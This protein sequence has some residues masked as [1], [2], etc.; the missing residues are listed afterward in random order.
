MKIYTKSGDQGETQVYASEVL[1]K[2]KDDALLQCYGTLDELN[3]HIGLLL[4]YLNNNRVPV[5]ENIVSD[6]QGKPN[7]EPASHNLK[8]SFIFTKSQLNDDYIIAVFLQIQKDIFNIG[9]ALSNNSQLQNESVDWLENLIDSMTKILPPQ[10]RFI[11]PGGG[12]I[13]SQTHICRTVARRAE[14]KLVSLSSHHECAPVVLQYM[15]RLSD[16]LF[17]FARWA[18]HVSGIADTEI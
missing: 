15:N 1:R 9:F 12:L 13:A 16:T 11:L 7:I 4:A 14:R 3:S 5:D 6:E 18:N 8:N 10:T 17:V 2:P